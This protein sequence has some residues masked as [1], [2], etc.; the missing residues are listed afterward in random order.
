MCNRHNMQY[1]PHI[2]TSYITSVS[3][4]ITFYFFYECCTQTFLMCGIK[5]IRISTFEF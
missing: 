3:F 5:T 4:F 1:F 2:L